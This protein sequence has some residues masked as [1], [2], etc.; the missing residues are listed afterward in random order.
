M[1]S[2]G[3]P[4]P[5]EH[6]SE[7]IPFLA[8]S[9]SCSAGWPSAP[10]PCEAGLCPL[11]LPIPVLHR[12]PP[13]SPQ[14]PPPTPSQPAR[15][16]GMTGMQGRQTGP[17]RAWHS[18]HGVSAE[19]SASHPTGGDWAILCPT[20]PTIPAIS[21]QLPLTLRHQCPPKE[22]DWAE[23]GEGAGR[24]R[25]GRA[26]ASGGSPVGPPAVENSRAAVWVRGEQSHKSQLLVPLFTALSQ[27]SAVS[28]RGSLF[29]QVDSG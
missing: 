15:G 25:E 1:E 22:K 13:C 27:D 6:L 9:W 8:A 4:T 18:G 17:R 29:L 26:G 28:S 11:W 14:V 7:Q 23:E 10:L 21:T 12:A 5:A 24:Q 16:C 20:T 2:S 3:L 19:T